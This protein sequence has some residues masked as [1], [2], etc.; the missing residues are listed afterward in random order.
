VE[1]IEY[2]LRREWAARNAGGGPR[3][4]YY[5]SA[6]VADQG[7]RLG[8]WHPEQADYRY[9]AAAPRVPGPGGPPR[10]SG[11]IQLPPAAGP[12]QQGSPWPQQAS[13]GRARPAGGA[14]SASMVARIMADADQ[15]AAAITRQATYQAARMTQQVAYEATGVREAAQ[16]EAD[17]LMM[18]AAVQ[19]SAVREAAELEAAEVREAVQLMQAELSEL[20]NRITSTLPNPVLP[21]TPPHRQSAARPPAPARPPAKPAEEAAPQAA[22]QPAPQAGRKPASGPGR[23]QAALRVAAIATSALVVA[24]IAAGVAEIG[25]H[26]FDFFV[27]RAAG[28]GETGPGGLQEDQGPGQPDAPKPTP[29]QVKAQSAA[30]TAVTV[31]HG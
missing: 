28:N 23:Q 18:R 3:P 5:H 29:T 4:G 14:D 25:L 26:G 10:I 19:A 31:H 24:G 16:R 17:D 1:P 11:P 22:G 13:S 9:Q 27:F 21:R 30:H 12:W 7:V 8:P 6:P 15:R 2:E 20:A